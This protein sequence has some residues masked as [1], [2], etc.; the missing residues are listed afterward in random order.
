MTN[1]SRHSVR[2]VR[3]NRSACGVQFGL[4]AG[5]GT[6]LTPLDLSSA[7]QA[8]VKSGSPSVPEEIAL[9]ARVSHL[10]CWR[11]LAESSGHAPH[12][13][14]CSRLSRPLR[15]SPGLLSLAEGGRIERL[16]LRPPR[17]SGPVAPL[18]GTL[19]RKA[20]V[21]LPIPCGTCRVQTG[22]D[23]RSVHLPWR[24]A[25]HSKPTARAAVR[26]PTGAEPCPV[27]SPWSGSS[28]SN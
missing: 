4:C 6:H 26:L 18:S 25:E 12:T 24:R 9:E 22:P 8:F 14:R 15:A 7:V 17:L 3:T 2:I 28:E 23:P 1:S 21:M 13:L 27:H 19:R 20:E 16:T 5:I 11:D 10:R